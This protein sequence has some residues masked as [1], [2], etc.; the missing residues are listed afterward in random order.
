MR[1]GRVS[2]DAVE[3]AMTRTRVLKRWAALAAA[4]SGI[5]S[6]TAVLAGSGQPSPWQMSFQQAAT[7]VME[8]IVWFHDFLLWLITAITLF[9]LVLLGIVI[10]KFNAKANPTPSKTT[11]NTLLEVMW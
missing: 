3:G 6:S 9:V 1:Q 2:T 4:V 11:H 7:P 5:F 10:F 8:N